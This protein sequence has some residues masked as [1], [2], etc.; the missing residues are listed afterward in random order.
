MTS[1][2]VADQL[3]DKLVGSRIS[4]YQLAV[5]VKDGTSV[6]YTKPTTD[7]FAKA[8]RLRK[9]DF[10]GVYDRRATKEMIVEDLLYAG[11]DE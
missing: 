8:M 10:A 11:M 6:N 9:H 5:F 1:S 4:S 3:I 2:E 7:L